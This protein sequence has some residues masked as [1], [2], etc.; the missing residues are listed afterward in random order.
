MTICSLVLAVATLASTEAFVPKDGWRLSRFAKI[1]G[2]RLVV[3]VPQDQAKAGGAARCTVDLTPFRGKGFRASVRASGRDLSKPAASWLGFKFMLHY[4]SRGVSVWPGAHGRTGT[5]AED[6]FA[7][8]EYD[9]DFDVDTAEL[10][11]GLQAASGR[12]EFDLSTLKIV[13]SEPLWPVVN[14]DRRV[15]YPDSV[16]NQPPLRGVMSPS[17]PMTEDDFRTLKEWGATLLRYQIVGDFG[18]VGQDRDLAKYDR[19]VN[20]KLD[21]LESTVIPLAR[22]YGLKVVVDVHNPPGGRL[23]NKDWRMYYE[24]KYAEHFVALWQ[25]IAARFAKHGDV[26]Y[27]YDLDNEP[28]QTDKAASDCDYWS[29]QRRAAEAV[30]AVDPTTP[31]VVE[32]NAWDS[33]DA[34]R[35]L[36]ALDMDNVIYQVHMYVPGEFTH[37]GVHGSPVGVAYPNAKKGWDRAYLKKVLEPVRAFEKRHG[38]KIYVGEFSAIAWADGADRYLADCI[39]IF[40][41]YGWDWTYHA[42]REW[43]GW[44]VEHETA[45]PKARPVPAADTP[46]KR[47]LLDGLKGLDTGLTAFADPFIGCSDNGHCFAAAAY[48]FGLVQAGP[49]TGYAWWDYC[50]GYRYADTR[51]LGFS[52]THISGTGCGDLGDVLVMPFTG[53]C[54]L[55]R[56]NF[57]SAYRKETQTAKPGC[58]AVTLD[59]NH[60]RVEIAVSAHS[61]LY[62]IA[63]S[64]DGQPR[65]FTDLQH[66]M[67]N[68]DPADIFKQILGADIRR[69][70]GR[71]FLGRVHRKT[72]VDREYSFAAEFDCDVTNVTR[73]AK[74]D[75]RE[76]GPRSVLDLD[77]KP[78]GTCHFRIGISTVSPEAALANLHAE[79]PDWNLARVRAA[80]DRAWNDLFSRAEAVGATKDQK[81]GWY[82]SLYHLCIHPSDIADVDGRYRGAD[83]KIARAPGG[84][85]YSTLSLWDTFRAAN[86]LYTLLVPE[87]VPDMV[88]SMVAHHRAAGFLP[89]WALWGKDNQC[90]IGSHAVPVV[91][92]AYLKGFGGVDWNAAYEAVRDTLR[93]PHPARRMEQWDVLDRYGYYP[94]DKVRGESVSRTLECAYDDACA[95]KFAAALGKAEDAAFFRNR[96]YNWTNVF[97]RTSGW[98]RGRDSTGTWRTPFDPRRVGVGAQGGRNDFTEGNSCQYSWHVMQHPRE[99]IA[100][101]G[102]PEKFVERLQGLFTDS[103]AITGKALDVTGLIGQYAHGNEPSHHTAYF[104]QFAGRGDLTA[105]YVREVCD[106]FYRLGPDGLCGNDDC[107][108]MSAWHLF[109]SAGFY[110][111]DPCGG[112]YVLGAPQLPEVRFRL[113]GGK[114]F[115]VVAKNL[116]A[117]NKFVKAVSL[118]GKPLDGFNLRH[119]DLVAGGR[120]VFEMGTVK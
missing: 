83:G 30:R 18:G 40:R 89:I 61:A 45:S 39:S 107:G 79:I 81:T 99:F 109:S 91:V 111:F 31:I 43:T 2:N 75:P 62:R 49:D 32:S 12:V 59:D 104:F 4:K 53:D 22:K 15:S 73:L 110:P 8:G 84:H 38:A 13:P 56:T 93:N 76:N 21:H 44:S 26:I 67:T 66:G 25:R 80:A 10:T 34:F 116:S 96:S 60:A 94:T 57:A 95:A 68:W 14:R 98:M 90:M 113:P 92:D 41:E 115:T 70:G 35:Y 120:L 46:R 24:P 69:E 112:D 86:P 78:G 3:D 71:L 20:G 74:R 102:G 52:Q 47:V 1:E 42:F 48:P 58:Y 7:F 51:I 97:D 54:D 11:L 6:R 9:P 105:K 88:N 17:K 100:L 28:V 82:T 108:Q 55:S 118:N 23:P 77:L 64:G 101:H 103:A 33:P 63:Y 114:V 85:Y 36:S 65:V 37:Q 5:F 87:R 117:A 119:A 27:G 72:W 106:R 50:G 16:R 19:W 29:V